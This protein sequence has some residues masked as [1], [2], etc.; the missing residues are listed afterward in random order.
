MLWKFQANFPLA[1]YTSSEY[2]PEISCKIKFGPRQSHANQSCS[3]YTNTLYNSC[4]AVSISLLSGFLRQISVWKKWSLWS[5]PLYVKRVQSEWQ[6]LHAKPTQCLVSSEGQFASP[7]SSEFL[8][9]PSPA[10]SGPQ[11]VEHENKITLLVKKINLKKL[12][13]KGHTSTTFTTM[14]PP[15]QMKINMKNKYRW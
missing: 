10:S 11:S 3:V 12:S 15:T 6:C 14:P 1:Y 4:K 2:P 13:N 7:V 8:P 9:Q 5:T